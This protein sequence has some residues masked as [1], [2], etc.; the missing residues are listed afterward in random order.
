MG[1][2]FDLQQRMSSEQTD[3][4]KSHTNKTLTAIKEVFFD[5]SGCNT[6]VS[7]IIM[8]ELFSL[9]L[10]N[11]RHAS[12]TCENYQAKERRKKEHSSI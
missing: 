10:T 12:L 1:V 7:Y 8:M 9:F 2:Y 4:E 5:F 11:F 6:Q 3:E